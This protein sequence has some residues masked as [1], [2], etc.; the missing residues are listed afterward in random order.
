MSLRRNHTRTLLLIFAFA[1]AA[2]LLAACGGE[3]EPTTGEEGACA[4]VDDPPAKDVEL[5]APTEKAPTASA[6]V[7][8]TSCGSFTVTLDPDTNPKTAAS[9][10]YLA[11]EGVYDDTPFHR[12]APGF[13]I[14]GGDPTGDGTGGPGYSITE[15]PPA[16][17]SYT[18]GLVAM[19]KTSAEPPG[20]SSSQFFSVTADADAGLPPDYAI[21]GEVTDGFETVEAIEALGGGAGSDGPPSQTVIT[22]TAT[23]EE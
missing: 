5:S 11:E 2:W 14:Q 4:T 7:F 23:V 12:V 10:Q 8:E 17:L 16:D 18:R 3:G 6:V 19:A 15:R 22:E 20:T 13:V 9:F 1:L 21:A